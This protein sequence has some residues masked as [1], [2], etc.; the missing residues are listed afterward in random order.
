MPCLIISKLEN[1][2]PQF[3]IYTFPFSRPVSAVF[4]QH[5]GQEGSEKRE[6]VL[7]LWVSSSG[8]ISSRES[9]LTHSPTQSCS[10][11][12]ASVRSLGGTRHM[13]AL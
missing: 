8:L 7:L 4:F 9:S 2:N 3:K 10:L 11:F 12:E 5:Q 1:P 13:F 6:R